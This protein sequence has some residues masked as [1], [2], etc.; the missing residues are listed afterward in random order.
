MAT[1]TFGAPATSSDPAISG[2]FSEDAQ[3]KF[4]RK[5]VAPI[6]ETP[7]RSKG[8]DDAKKKKPRKPKKEK[9]EAPTNGDLKSES[10]AENTFE[11]FVGNLPLATKKVELERLFKPYG[12]V[13]SARLR[14]VP[15]L[16]TA[17]DEAGNA[18]LVKK[19]CVIKSKFSDTKDSVNG[20]VVF[21]DETSARR[22]IAEANGIEFGGHHLRVDDGKTP[23]FDS[24][25]SVFLGNVPTAATEEQVWAH[26][27][28]LLA[29]HA[30][31][32]AADDDA[33]NATAKVIQGVRLVRD[34]E[35]FV[36]KGFG[37]V[38]L[39]DR[40]AAAAALTLN[41]TKLS[42]RE[43]RVQVCG[44]RFKGKQGRAAGDSSVSA[45]G[46]EGGGGDRHDGDDAPVQTRKERR[47]GEAAAK[48][49]AASESGTK[50]APTAESSAKVV[51][52]PFQGLTAENV[53]KPLSGAER[54]LSGK[55]VR[56]KWCCCRS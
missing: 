51:L 23:T 26:F 47:A 13:V 56:R 10:T 18:N 30:K 15:V 21:K 46:A 39:R 41:G 17:V 33:A 8:S 55:K 11:V 1:F 52:L 7:K 14:S 38:L 24:S 54:R 34:A 35:T 49:A 12:S 25:R 4:A 5:D 40:A 6:V 53:V 45:G 42:G 9:P 48:A 44:K 29:G 19:V 22:A 27:S 16:G 43:L 32:S 31:T 20:Y 36:G 50:L 2:L 37:Y 3:K 28:R